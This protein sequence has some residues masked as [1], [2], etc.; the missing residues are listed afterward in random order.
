MMILMMI[1]FFL[2]VVIKKINFNTFKKPLNVISAVYNGEI[3]LN[4][5]K[6]S[7]KN[8]EKKRAKSEL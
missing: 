4:E 3:S 2:L 1:S 6:F 8:L 7:Q 5:A